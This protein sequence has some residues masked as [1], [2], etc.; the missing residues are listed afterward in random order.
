MGD[1]G[2]GKTLVISGIFGTV[3]DNLY[4][5]IPGVRCILFSNNPSIKKIS[6]DRGWEFKFVKIHPL[7]DDYRLSLVQSKYVKF[8]QFFNEFPEFKPY[9]DIVYFDHKFEVQQAHLDWMDKAFTA[10]KAVL[11]RNTPRLKSSIQDEINDA[12]CQERY[13]VTMPQTIAWLERTLEKKK[14]SME[15]R[16]MNTGLMKYRD[17][18]GIIPLLD[19]VYQTVW[20]LA[21][22]ECQ[23]I[24]AC[25][26]QE[27]EDLIQ[28]V[29][30]DMLKPR[31]QAP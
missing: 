29:D 14:L 2:Q 11:I 15:T 19:E 4:E 24:W 5:S 7:S 23:I 6:E 22:P 31:W 3:F 13:T 25:L 10:G 20:R 18:F 12:M 16:I 30:W 9:T 21:Q 1:S 17:F 28:R 8:L 26:S 27:Y